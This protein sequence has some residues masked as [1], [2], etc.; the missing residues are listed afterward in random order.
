MAVA[1]RMPDFGT[2]VD[3][4]RIVRWLV[5]EGARVSRGTILVGLETDR[6][7]TELESIAEGV[8]LK[9]CAAQGA[10]VK[11]G[12]IIAYVGMPGEQI[13]GALPAAGKAPAVAAVVANLAAKL[14]VD[15]A[16]VKATGEGGRTTRDD[17]LRA[18]QAGPKAAA[19]PARGQAAVARAVERSHREI[20]PLTVAVSI[21]M[22]AALRLRE[23]PPCAGRKAFFDALFLK[24]MALAL[25]AVPFI[26]SARPPGI[27][28]A[29]ACGHGN[30]LVLPVVRE[31]NRKDL[32]VLQDEIA[33][34]TARAA[35]GWLKLEE[36]T[37]G[38]LALSNLGM[39]PVDWFE[40]M[41][42]P[43][44]VAV[45]ALGAVRPVPVVMDGS[46]E[47]RPV[48]SCTLTADHRLVNGRTAAD[49]LTRIKTIV[50]A[51]LP[52]K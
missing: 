50:E 35:A 28:I 10:M 49:Y 21:D 15:L 36:M 41:V 23:R 30:D 8:V 32:A 17:V 14:G 6:A 26:A 38:I 43:G 47:A 5:E 13:D 51:G 34:L 11:S 45:L 20:P 31:V 37:G 1:I 16:G 39:Y 2:A 40:A 48:V 7:A 46:I 42:F 44:H 27:H 33:A 19:A 24:A 12:E 52:A 22:S 9:L 29:F 18:R 4:I 25:E 3:E